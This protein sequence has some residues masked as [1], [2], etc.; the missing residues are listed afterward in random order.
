LSVQPSTQTLLLYCPYDRRVTRHLRRGSN[1]ALVCVECGRPVDADDTAEDE[2]PQVA[3]QQTAAISQLPV[4]RRSRVRPLRRP[5][6][7][8][9]SWLPY[10]LVLIIVGTG[11]VGAASVAMSIFGPGGEASAGSDAAPIAG[12]RPL[13]RDLGGDPNTP[14]PAAPGAADPAPAAASG[15]AVRVTNTG[16]VGAFLRRTPSLNDRL[17]AW[18]DNT[19]LKV[20]GPD[21]NAEGVQWKHVEDPAGNRGWIPAQYTRP[22]SGA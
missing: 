11:I 15:A 2:D 9:T 3:L 1:L 22:E 16:G 7:T 4:R 19:V 12:I 14:V 6:R 21:T 18:P 5:T 8:R 17:R 13:G 20:V 10:A